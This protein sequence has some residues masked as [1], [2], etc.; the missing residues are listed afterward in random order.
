MF[1][2]IQRGTAV[3]YLL[4]GHVGGLRGERV[5]ELNGA[6]YTLCDYETRNIAKLL[7]QALRQE[8]QVVLAHGHE[9]DQIC[10]VEVKGVGVV[11]R[12]DELLAVFYLCTVYHDSRKR[13]GITRED[14]RIKVAGSNLNHKNIQYIKCKRNGC[15]KRPHIY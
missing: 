4:W 2:Q 14:G 8:H 12:R 5:T 3:P 9:G 10:V 11:V 13:Y 1:I 15:Q 7:R 6:R